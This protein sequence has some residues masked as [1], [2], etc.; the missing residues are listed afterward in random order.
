MLVNNLGQVK[1][2]DLGSVSISLRVNRSQRALQGH[3]IICRLKESTAGNIVM[4]HPACIKSHC[5]VC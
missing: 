4:V 1:I 5:F 3:I 2:S